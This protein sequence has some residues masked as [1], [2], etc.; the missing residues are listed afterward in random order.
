MNFFSILG[1]ILLCLI[2]LSAIIFIIPVKLTVSKNPAE[3]IKIIIRVLFIPIKITLKKK[4]KKK[5]NK[6]KK[7]KEAPRQD[8]KALTFREK[9]IF[10]CSLITNALKELK[11][12]LYHVR[13]SDLS[14][15]ISLSEANAAFTAIAVGGINAAVYPVLGLIESSARVDKGAY[16]INVAPEYNS[17]KSSFGFSLSIHLAVIHLLIGGIKFYN[18]YKKENKRL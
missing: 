16:K 7:Q 15:N 1:I 4:T 18:F 14:L 11:H 17:G 6:P 13:V 2:A 10:Y 8:K 5:D 9:V 3:N 12:I